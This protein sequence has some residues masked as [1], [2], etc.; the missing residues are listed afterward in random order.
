MP[1]YADL[2]KAAQLR[3]LRSIAKRALPEFNLDEANVSLAYHGYNTTFRVSTSSGDFALRINVGSKRTEH[4]IAGEVAWIEALARETDLPVPTPQRTTEGKHFAQVNCQ[5]LGRTFHCVLYRWLPGR[6]L[7]R[8]IGVES[9]EKVGKLLT[10]LHDHAAS[11][12]FPPCTS[13]PILENVLDSLPWRLPNEPFWTDALDEAQAAMD[14]LRNQPRIICHFDVHLGNVKLHKGEISVFDFDDSLMAWPI[15]DIAQS[16][17]YMR[18]KINAESV[19]AAMWKGIGRPLESYGLTRAQFEALVVGR[20]LLLA[21]DLL[22]NENADF[23]AM[24]P[25]YIER[26]RKRIEAWRKTG[27]F[28]SRIQ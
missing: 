13:R 16:M 1:A 9:S 6:H 5:E 12:Q 3:A 28:D 11:F 22:G 23:R 27:W 8:R 20:A 17:F 10:D 21:C 25:I 15:L 7:S 19:E 18:S 14:T 2:P 24:T 26:T 4:D